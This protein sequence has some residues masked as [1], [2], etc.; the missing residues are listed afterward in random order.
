MN[1]KQTIL[2]PLL[3]EYI[4]THPELYHI[5][6]SDTELTRVI[7]VPK[8]EL[9]E[10]IVNVPFTTKWYDLLDSYCRWPDSLEQEWQEFLGFKEP[11]ECDI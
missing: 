3:G 8:S 6:E 11:K 5:C 9:I 4:I 1:Y 2:A 7:P 10:I